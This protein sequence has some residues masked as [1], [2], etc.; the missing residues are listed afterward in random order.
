M[1]SVQA[2]AGLAA[3]AARPAP[4]AWTTAA[5]VALVVAA[6]VVAVALLS[7]GGAA[8]S[9]PASGAVIGSVPLQRARCVDWLGASGPERAATVN[10]LRAAVGGG[11][12]TPYGQGSTLPPGTTRALF[13]GTCSRAYANT[14]LLYEIYIRAAAFHTYLPR[15]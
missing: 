14:F 4:R 1:R 8:P 9:R 13:D 7:Q 10:A 15:R 11:T 2:S 3:P 12:A 6:A 5:L